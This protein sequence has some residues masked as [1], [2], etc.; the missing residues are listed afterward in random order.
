VEAALAAHPWR[1]NVRELKN[2]VERAVYQAESDVIERVVFDPFDSPF[3]PIA[4][5]RT[6]GEICKDET[7]GGEVASAASEAIR[8]DR[9][10]GELVEA[11]ERRLLC[12]ALEQTRFNQR[13]AATLLGLTYH[14]FRGLYRKYGIDS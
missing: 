9:P 11:Y 1:G 6:T 12:A 2:V 8:L 7:L 5:A 10:F 4:G 3:A 13:K 14:Q